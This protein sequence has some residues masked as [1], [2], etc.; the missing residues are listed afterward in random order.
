MQQS[1]RWFG[2]TDPVTLS[3]IRQAGARGVVTALHD[4]PNGTAWPVETIAARKA[5]IEAAV[6]TLERAAAHGYA[7][8]TSAATYELA[9]VYADFGRALMQSERPTQLQGDALEQYAILLEEQAF[10]F[11]E[12][13][14]RAHE[15][16]LSR[17]R[18]GIWNDAIDA[19]VAALG[20]LSPAKYGKQEQREAT[21]DE[22][23]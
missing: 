1:W 8:I 12:K 2:P 3:D 17:L 7:E 20:E 19:S 11:E 18:Q 15:I 6:G 13:A 23:H 16:N 5:A 22:L 14:I 21:Y 9:S 10:P 4:V